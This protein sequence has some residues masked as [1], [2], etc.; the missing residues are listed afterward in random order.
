MLVFFQSSFY[1]LG[2]LF[3]LFIVRFRLFWLS[4]PLLGLS[5]P[6]WVPFQLSFP[7][8]FHFRFH[9]HFRV[10]LTSVLATVSSSS[11]SSSWFSSSGLRASPVVVSAVASSVVSPSG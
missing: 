11:S 7:F 9:F 4:S 10:F 1:T 2:F 5:P 8:S 3:F 6:F